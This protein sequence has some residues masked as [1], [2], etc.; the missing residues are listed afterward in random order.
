M[1]DNITL[2]F[3]LILQLRAAVLMPYGNCPEQ[4]YMTRLELEREGITIRKN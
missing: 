2:L 4:R 3:K 1:I